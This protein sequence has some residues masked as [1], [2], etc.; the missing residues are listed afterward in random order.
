[1]AA[2]VATAASS[3]ITTAASSTNSGIP[4]IPPNVL[5]G[6][7]YLCN[8]DANRS[9]MCWYDNA[10][11]SS[12][13][14]TPP[15]ATD[16]V[17]P[18]DSVVTWEGQVVRG[19]IMPSDSPTDFSTNIG[20]DGATAPFQSQVGTASLL[21]LPAP[22]QPASTSYYADFNVFK[23]DLRVLYTDGQFG[24][25]YSVYYCLFANSFHGLG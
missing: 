7:A 6:I 23:D 13:G 9:V 5:T 18:S 22:G 1:M 24:Q 16:P 4:S 21:L 2:T 14:I 10:S 20:L 19:I 3:T 15:Q 17:G 25:V 11:A 8:T 12:D